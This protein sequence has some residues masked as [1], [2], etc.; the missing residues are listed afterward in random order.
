[1][2]EESG[3]GSVPAA[4]VSVAVSGDGTEMEVTIYGVPYPHY[5]ELFPQHVRDFQSRFAGGDE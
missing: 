3:F 1:M 5:A 2:L 4:D